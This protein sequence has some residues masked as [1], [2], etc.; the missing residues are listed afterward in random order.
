MPM[1]SEVE[2]RKIGAKLRHWSEKPVSQTNARAL[3]FCI[4]GFVLT[5]V[6]AR[7]SP[8]PIAAV[9]S[10]SVMFIAVQAAVHYLAIASLRSLIGLGVKEAETALEVYRNPCRISCLDIAM[11]WTAVALIARYFQ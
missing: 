1:L 11:V 2:A 7:H 10:I 6:A 3:A 4:I 9:R 8:D 5:L